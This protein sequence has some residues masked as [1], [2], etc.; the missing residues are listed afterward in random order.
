LP[1]P[2]PDAV[3]HDVLVLAD[4]LQP[5]VTEMVPEPADA[6]RDAL[7]GE[8]VTEQE[9]PDWVKLKDCPPMLIVPVRLPVAVFPV[10]E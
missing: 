5:L 10:A 9:V 2:L 6:G 4:Q 3:I 1:D 8:I 7:V